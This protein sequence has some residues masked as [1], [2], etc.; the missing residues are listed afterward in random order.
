MPD[1]CSWLESIRY[2]AILTGIYLL[3]ITFAVYV[4]QPS[5]SPLRQ[6]RPV[7][8]TRAAQQPRLPVTAPVRVMAG[9][10]VRLVI[11]DD[12]IDLPVD[13]GF[14]NSSDDSWTLS[15]YHAQFAMLSTLAN[16]V[17]GETFVY[18]HNNNYVFGPLRHATPPVGTTA[19]IYTD[20]G[21]I[22]S[23]IFRGVH[24]VG[25]S[26][27]TVLAYDGPPI[28][29]IQTC[30]GSLNEWRTEFTFAFDKVVQ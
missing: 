30:T 7:A 5:L 2:S 18:G 4:I 13:E 25:P 20:N 10:P 16:N 28:L 1:D 21:H 17:G 27:T 12:G 11:A 26:E 29:L 23:Y 9:R 19:L 15:G 6:S 22:F 3:T 8:L 24:S 14:Y